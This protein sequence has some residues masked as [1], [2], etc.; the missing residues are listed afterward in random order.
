MS[1]P[2]NV[3]EK[4]RVSPRHIHHIISK[5]SGWH[6]E[7]TTTVAKILASKVIQ[8]ALRAWVMRVRAKMEMI[9]QRRR[10]SFHDYRELEKFGY[11]GF[12]QSKA[13]EG[14][15]DGNGKGADDGWGYITGNLPVKSTYQ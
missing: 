8:R 15:D 7:E 4:T 9:K 11:K 6:E 10:L 13:Y 2:N 5:Q 12:D 14:K 1:V 3:L